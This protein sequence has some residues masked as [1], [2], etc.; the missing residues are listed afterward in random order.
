MPVNSLSHGFMHSGETN[1]AI[2]WM[3]WYIRV[4]P[5]NFFYFYR[6][7]TRSVYLSLFLPH[8]L[9]FISPLIKNRHIGHPVCFRD[10]N[11]ALESLDTWL[12][13]LT[14]NVPE[15]RPLPRNAW[16]YHTGADATGWQHCRWDPRSELE[17]SRGSR[18]R[19]YKRFKVLVLMVYS[20]RLLIMSILNTTKLIFK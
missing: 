13:R 19:V 6:S 12:L 4:W 16:H 18:H 7:F 1:Y 5:S 11:S 3:M 17:R 14:W 10:W 20:G 9:H 8:Q 15:T 2:A